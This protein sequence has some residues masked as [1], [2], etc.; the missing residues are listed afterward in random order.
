M[1]TPPGFSTRKISAKT[2]PK[3]TKI[4]MQA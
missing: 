1:H 2:S 4:H 3:L